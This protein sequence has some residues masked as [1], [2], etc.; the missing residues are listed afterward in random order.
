MVQTNVCNNA[1]KLCHASDIEKTD[2]FSNITIPSV[3]ALKDSA[4]HSHTHLRGLESDPDENRVLKSLLITEDPPNAEPHSSS[5]PQVIKVC[6][7]S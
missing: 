4:D 7:S 1:M 6:S 5:E 3:C 2:T